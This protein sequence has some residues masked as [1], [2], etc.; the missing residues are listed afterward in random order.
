MFGRIK[1]TARI[2]IACPYVGSTC[3]EGSHTFEAMQYVSKALSPEQQK[4]VSDAL[5]KSLEQRVAHFEAQHK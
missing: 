1:I 4:D 5:Y 2:Q 3:Y